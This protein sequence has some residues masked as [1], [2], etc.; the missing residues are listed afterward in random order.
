MINFD[1]LRASSTRTSPYQYIIS[2]NVITKEQAAEVRRDYPNIKQ[3]GYLPLSKLEATGAF[4]RLIDDLQ[5][6]ELAEILSDKLGLDLMDKPRMITVRRLSK[7]GDGRIHNDSKSKICT[8]LIYL[9]EDWD[10]AEGGAIRAL[11]GKTDMD[12]YAEE[13]SPLAGN[14][15]AFKRSE[16]SWH[17]H[18]SFKGERY[19]V[20]TTFLISEEE[21]ARKEKRG[22]L[23]TKL[24]RLLRIN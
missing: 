22:G 17:G 14:V 15:F 6:P 23:Q 11:N 18:P 10:N 21:R 13:V 16:S 7:H 12:D 8:M 2:E 3:T 4:K 19:V 20:Q 5:K 1:A 9:N 24:K